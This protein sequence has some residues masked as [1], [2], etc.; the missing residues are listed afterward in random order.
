MIYE[1]VVSVSER[2]IFECDICWHC[3]EGILKRVVLRVSEWIRMILFM[4][5]RHLDEG[6][7]VGCRRY[8]GSI[9]ILWN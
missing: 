4:K 6:I 9:C 2:N 5:R 7:I 8:S 3:L 1:R